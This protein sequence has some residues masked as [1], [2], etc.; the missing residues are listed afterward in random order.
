[1]KTKILAC[2]I[3]CAV[4]LAETSAVWSVSA[5]QTAAPGDASKA[6]AYSKAAAAA[7]ADDDRA[8]ENENE[9]PR[10]KTVT[11]K[12]YQITSDHVKILLNKRDLRPAYETYSLLLSG[13]YP[14][15]S[16]DKTL[17]QPE[18]TARISDWFLTEDGYQRVDR[19]G[20]LAL[21]EDHSVYYMTKYVPLHY[22]RFDAGEGKTI[23]LSA[24]PSYSGR[25]RSVAENEAILAE[26][27][28]LGN[29]LPT[30]EWGDRAFLGWFTAPEGGEEITK[31]T[32]ISGDKELTFYAHWDKEGTASPR[33]EY[34]VSMLYTF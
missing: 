9:D 8:G 34:Y 23:W 16:Y 26:Q 12:A 15:N 17:E 29:R 31:D 7:S 4:L 14:S 30:A 32:P 33:S 10:Q 20:K 6:V 19:Y 11:V 27:D 24:K 3:A 22:V 28:K 5:A 18:D 25:V 13:L 1:M 21:E 2:S